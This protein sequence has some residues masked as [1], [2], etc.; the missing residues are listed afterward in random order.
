MTKTIEKRITL[1]ENIVVKARVRA[2]TLGI[3]LTEYVQALV[4]QDVRTNKNDPWL[5]PVPKEV[6][7]RWEKDLAETEEQEKL[8]P[9]AGAKMANELIRLLDE[10]AACLPDD[11]GD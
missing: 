10:E 5:E 7:E 6:D 1:S 11:E 4:D 3:S 2:H 8:K 9:R